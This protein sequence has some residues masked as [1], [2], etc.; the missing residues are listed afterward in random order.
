MA[1]DEVLDLAMGLEGAK[2][3]SNYVAAVCPFHGDNKPSML[4]HKD[5]YHCLA[6]DAKGRTEELLETASLRP[7]THR[8][9]T[10]YHPR[11]PKDMDGDRFVDAAH[12]ML[13]KH[14]EYQ[15][16]LIRRGIGKAVRRYHIGYWDGWYVIPS[17]TEA[18]A[19]KDILFRS[20]PWVQQQTGERFFQRAGQK[21]GIYVPDWSLDGTTLFVVFGLFDAISLALLGYPA[22]T[23]SMGKGGIKSDWFASWPYRIVVLPDQGEEKQ[24]N[25]LA[26]GLDWR[27]RAYRLPY[28]EG[29]KDPNDYLQLDQEGLRRELNGL[30]KCI[31]NCGGAGNPGQ[32]QPRVHRPAHIG[33]TL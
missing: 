18:G 29:C 27:G 14:D 20:G 2:R 13:V 33:A 24:A 12:R 6:C 19:L 30:V 31:T 10:A 25:I 1:D 5:F 16:Y 32:D 22:A 23:P 8:S 9:P 21:P 3:Y 17:Y 15:E 4:I 26:A 28:P 7:I 11:I